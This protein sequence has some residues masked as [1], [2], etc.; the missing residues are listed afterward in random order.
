LGLA[1]AL[2]ASGAATSIVLLGDPL[3]LPQVSQATHPDGSG[4][5]VLEHL[6]GQG[7]ATVPR[8]R[9]V[10][11]TTTRRM[12]PDVCTFISKEIYERRLGWHE[13]CALQSTAAGTGLRWLRATHT[14]CVTDSVEEA[15]MVADEIRRLLGKGWVDSDGKPHTLTIDDVMVVAPYNDQVRLM[16]KV[17]GADPRL[18]GTKVGTVDKFQGQQAPVVFFTMTSSSSDDMPRGSDFLFSRN[19]LNVAISRAKCLAYVVCT[20]ELLNS[21]AKTIEEMKL[22]STLCAAVA[23]A[24]HHTPS[25]EA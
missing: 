16:R 25:G 5:S 20:D 14:D 11:L 13:S 22:I 10:F 3:Q 18:A 4:V 15:E 2:S 12:H 1:D 6:L 7:V 23:Y 21:R 8:E 19:R 24:Q 9:G 17:F